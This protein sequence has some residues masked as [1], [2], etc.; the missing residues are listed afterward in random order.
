MVRRVQ[1][2]ITWKK[3]IIE[4]AQEAKRPRQVLRVVPRG[5]EHVF[6]PGQLFRV[7]FPLEPIAS[8]P[9]NQLPPFP[10]LS[11]GWYS[12]SAA[13]HAGYV[14]PVPEGSLAIFV[15]HTRVEEM[16]GIHTISLLRATF[17]ICGTRY[18]PT[19]LN[20]FDFVS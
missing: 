20:C 16:D 5:D 14:P 4:A 8:H 6:V 12:P 10:Y 2:R 18:M 13:T 7:N 19:D 1:K 9:R 15:G 17:F 11:K 3:D